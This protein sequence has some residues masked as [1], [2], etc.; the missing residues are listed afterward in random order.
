MLFVSLTVE[1]GGFKWYQLYQ[2]LGENQINVHRGCERNLHFY[3]YGKMLIA[4]LASNSI[5]KL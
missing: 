1:G 3:F 2:P 4:K 5:L